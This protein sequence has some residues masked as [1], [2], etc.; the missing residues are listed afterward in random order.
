MQKPDAP[1]RGGDALDQAAA[2]TSEHLQRLAALAAVARQACE[3]LQIE[4]R[5]AEARLDELTLQSRMRALTLGLDTRVAAAAQARVV[6]A[7]RLVRERHALRQ[8]EQLMR[9]LEMSS[10]TL[11]ASAPVD[12]WALALRAQIVH[13]REEERARLAREVHDGPAQVLANDLMLLELCC[14]LAQQGADPRLTQTLDQLR[15]ATRAGLH[16]VRRFIADLRPAN[17]GSAGLL[18]AVREYV[19]SF[20]SATGIVVRVEGD[21]GTHLGDEVAITLYRIVQEALQNVRKYAP[22]AGVLVSLA[23]MPALVTLAIRDDGPG[24][25]PHEVARRAGRSNWGLTSM[26]ERAE[27]VGATL[28]VTSSP[29][30]G[31]EVLVSLPH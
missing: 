17:L 21:A 29:G 4:E 7:D 22:R 10:G 15:D 2:I 28:R 1:L 27:L 19:R 5:R 9:Q 18:A 13:G 31:T 23:Q 6:L 3:H 16:E 26:R 30:H 12:P 24:F 14:D 8:I 20:S 11:S 25:D